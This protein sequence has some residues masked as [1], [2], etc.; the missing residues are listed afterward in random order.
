MLSFSLF[1]GKR[2]QTNKSEW[3]KIN[4]RKKHENTHTQREREREREREINSISSVPVN[5]PD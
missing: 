2:Q 4:K 3:N 1:L 5:N